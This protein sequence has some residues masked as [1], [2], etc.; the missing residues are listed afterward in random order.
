MITLPSGQSEDTR[1]SVQR[2]ADDEHYLDRAFYARDRGHTHAYF[3][4][5]GNPC[6]MKCAC[7]DWHYKER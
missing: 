4:W 3:Q 7:G 5:T 1:S 2:H 6:V